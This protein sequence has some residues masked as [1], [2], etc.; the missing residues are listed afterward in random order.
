[1]YKKSKSGI[2][3]P[4]KGIYRN[5]KGEVIFTEEFDE[6]IARRKK[7]YEQIDRRIEQA[8]LAKEQEELAR[9]KEIVAQLKDDLLEI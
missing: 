2:F 5:E 8:K 4:Y 1:M 6:D 9:K 3:R 7:N